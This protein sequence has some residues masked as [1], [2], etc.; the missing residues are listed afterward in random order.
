MDEG[1]DFDEGFG[2]LFSFVVSKREEDLRSGREF[3]VGVVVRDDL[4]V[5]DGFLVFF[6]S[7]GCRSLLEVLLDLLLGEARDG[8][9][10]FFGASRAEGERECCEERAEGARR[11]SEA[12]EHG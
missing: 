7:E 3:G 11:F 12:G 9:V 6:V 2:F 8:V 1:F 10:V 4:E 5:L